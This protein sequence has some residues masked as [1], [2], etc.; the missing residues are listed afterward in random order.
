MSALTDRLFQLMRVNTF[1][2]LVILFAVKQT[3]R[4]LTAVVL[5]LYNW[6]VCLTP[7]L[8]VLTVHTLYL[9][10]SICPFAI[11]GDR[12]AIEIGAVHQYSAHDVPRHTVSFAHAQ[13]LLIAEN[14]S[15]NVMHLVT[16]NV[17]HVT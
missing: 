9:P 5:L 16:V 10:H 4:T 6:F 11:K 1:L 12:V 17:S 13:A 15:I 2:Y 8:Y 14:I 7:C 3:F